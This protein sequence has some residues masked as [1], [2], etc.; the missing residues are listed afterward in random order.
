MARSPSRTIQLQVAPHLQRQLLAGL[1]R[2]WRSRSARVQPGL[3]P[4][5]EVDLLLGV[6]QR[7]LADLLEVGADRVGRGGHLGVLA[8]LPQRLGLLLVPGELV[9]LAL[10]GLGRPPRSRR[11]PRRRPRS[12]RA[13]ASSAD[14]RPGSAA[15]PILAAPSVRG[16]GGLLGRRLLRGGLLGRGLLG[17][18]LGRARPTRSVGRAASLPSGGRADGLGARRRR[19][20]ASCGEASNFRSHGSLGSHV[21]PLIHASRT[22]ER[23]STDPLRARSVSAV[24]SAGL[25]VHPWSRRSATAMPSSAPYPCPFIVT[26]DS[27]GVPT[28]RQAGP[29]SAFG[30]PAIAAPTMPALFSSWAGRP[31]CAAR[32]AAP[33]CRRPC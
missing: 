21:R 6:E 29:D 4:L 23:G 7:H 3:D 15:S 22:D 1:A 32:A 24:G 12:P 5:G 13:R 8:G 17:R 27:A 2:S 25:G 9:G 30:A 19:G 28:R 26:R 20:L 11:R 10:G 18:R 16:C 31:G 33:S 14:R